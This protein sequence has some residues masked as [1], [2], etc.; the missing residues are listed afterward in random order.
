MKVTPVLGV[1]WAAAVC[2]GEPTLRWVGRCGQ[3]AL[4]DAQ[5]CHWCL[6]SPVVTSRGW[7]FGGG[8]CGLAYLLR[9]PLVGSLV[10]VV[11]SAEVGNN[12]RNRQSNDQHPA[13]GANGAKY[14]PSN[15]LGH[16]VTITRGGKKTKGKPLLQTSATAPKAFSGSLRAQ[17]RECPG[18]ALKLGNAPCEERF[19]WCP[20]PATTIY[21]TPRSGSDLG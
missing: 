5:D 6:V 9:S 15:C 13:Q 1:F 20:Q 8:G 19:P 14:L 4:C 18:S 17:H 11:N 7:A 10:L 3:A 12:D 16:H 21:T 2:A